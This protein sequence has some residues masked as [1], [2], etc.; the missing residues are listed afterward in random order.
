MEEGYYRDGSVE[1]DSDRSSPKR[2]KPVPGLIPLPGTALNL[3][4]SSNESDQKNDSSADEE[5]EDARERPDMQNMQQS[6]KIIS[7]LLSR[8]ELS[9]DCINKNLPS[10]SSAETLA[11]KKKNTTFFDKLKE[12]LIT[13]SGDTENLM[14][15]CLYE[16]KSLSDLI[17]HQKIC[18][19]AQEKFLS[20]GNGSNA[21]NSTR[22][23]FCRHRC[24]S[25]ADLQQHLQQCAHSR[26]PIECLDSSSD[27][28]GDDK[29]G[30]PDYMS[31]DE[32]MIDNPN[33]PHPMENRVFVWNN[34]QKGD[35][36]DSN[37][38]NNDDSDD[39]N[40]VINQDNDN[41]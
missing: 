11:L 9:V 7:S 35:Q 39:N 17:I 31:D 3:S 8:P 19:K 1:G 24:K 41:G 36:S 30:T 40:L 34:V 32:A 14:C 5:E 2:K 23:Q 29:S 21:M 38:K 10:T 13:N 16:A 33:E 20:P 25:N 15:K 28:N 18:S 12:K 26:S 22:C 6:Y 4:K 37:E 27:A